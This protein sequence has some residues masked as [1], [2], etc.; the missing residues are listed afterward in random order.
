MPAGSFVSPP[1]P[2]R[3]AAR[4]IAV[5]GTIVGI[6]TVAVFTDFFIRRHT[7]ALPQRFHATGE[8]Q[9]AEAE[10]ALCTEYASQR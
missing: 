5:S 4:C 6:V 1:A 9:R 7:A 8:F 10:A 3:V 2:S